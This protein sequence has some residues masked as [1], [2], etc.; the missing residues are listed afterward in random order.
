MLHCS[1]SPIEF[2][3]ILFSLLLLL[4][5]DMLHCSISPI[6]FVRILFSLL[7][8]LLGD[9]LHCSISPIEFVR[10]LFSLLLLLLFLSVWILGP[11]YLKNRINNHVQIFTVSL[12]LSGIDRN[13]L[14]SV[15][16][17]PRRHPGAILCFDVIIDIFISV[18]H[19]LTKFNTHKLQVIRQHSDNPCPCARHD[20]HVRTHQN[21]NMLKITYKQ[22]W[23]RTRSFRA[24]QN[25]PSV[26]VRAPVVRARSANEWQKFKIFTWFGFLI[27]QL[28]ISIHLQSLLTFHKAVRARQSLK[29]ARAAMG[30]I[31]QK[32]AKTC[33]FWNRN[34]S[35]ERPFTPNFYIWL[36]RAWVG[37]MISYHPD[38]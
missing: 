1:I 23:A 31:M 22:F 32:W 33:H 18:Y 10:I 2:V 15:I 37:D 30:N 27:R 4:L 17:Q 34:S 12:S 25:F 26:R 14:F 35:S 11:W 7:L 21:F 8:L 28:T 9:M 6:E 38:S 19:K 29:S 24:F 3:R 16:T 13:K 5:G 20:A 36:E